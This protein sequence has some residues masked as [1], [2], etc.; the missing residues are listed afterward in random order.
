EPGKREEIEAELDRIAEAR[1]RFRAGSYE[2]L[3]I[4]AGVARAEL[5]G[6]DGG[7]D[8]V[9]AAA[10]ALTAAEERSSGVT[11]EL[12]AA[13]GSAADRFAEAVAAEL[14]GIGMNEGE[15]RLGP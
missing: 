3:L 15:F 6:L 1:R 4:R 14:Q 13:R 12:R 2:E 9:E 5:D 8:P 10:R 11:D 7:V